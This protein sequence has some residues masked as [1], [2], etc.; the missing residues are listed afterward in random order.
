M[1]INEI[2]NAI[3]D[4]QHIKNSLN[5]HNIDII[6]TPIIYNSILISRIENNIIY[7]YIF[8]NENLDYKLFNIEINKQINNYLRLIK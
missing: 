4:Y 3:N 6:I 5:E 2:T 8:V 7:Y 1:L